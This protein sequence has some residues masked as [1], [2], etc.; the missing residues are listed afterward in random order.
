MRAQICKPRPGNKHGIVGRAI[1]AC[2]PAVF[3][4]PPVGPAV[5]PAFISIQISTNYI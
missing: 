4:S 3:A 1:R 5:E 2:D